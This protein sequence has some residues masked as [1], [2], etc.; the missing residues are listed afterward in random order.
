[1]SDGSVTRRAALGGAALGVGATALAGRGASAQ[2]RARKTYVLI[3]GAFHGGWSWRRVSDLLERHGHKVLAPSLTGC[4]D[5]HHLLTKDVNLDTHIADIVNLVEWEDLDAIC[6]VAHSYGGWPASGALERILARVSAIVWLDAFKPEDG[7]RG[8]DY[9]SEF[10]RKA[11]A[12]A[13]EKGEPG[14]A[15]PKAEAFFVNEKDRAWVEARLTRQPNG[16]AVQPIRL[17]GAREKVAR[18]TYIRAPKY[19]QPAFD[20]AYAECK[21]DTSWQTFETNAGHDVMIDAPEWLADVLL[22]VS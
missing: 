5:R 7:Q 15:P 9:A 8:T 13:I 14:R 3:H 11:L 16:V 22:Q 10:S 12:E 2:S 6:L 20:K 4:G 17:T 18:K 19:P 1:M 21:A